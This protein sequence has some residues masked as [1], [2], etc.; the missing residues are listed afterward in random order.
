[1]F[2]SVLTVVNGDCDDLHENM[3][4]IQTR[5]MRDNLIFNGKKKV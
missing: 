1:M 4:D 3:L 5:W 2:E